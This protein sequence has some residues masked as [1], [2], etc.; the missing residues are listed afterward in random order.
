MIPSNRFRDREDA[1]RRL[2]VPLLGYTSSNPIVLGLPRGG[3]PVA[4]EVARA[5]GAPLDVWVVRKLGVPWQPE[6]AMG[7]VAEGGVVF[8]DDAL[9]AR[10]GIGP[11][12]VERERERKLL[13]VEQRVRQYR[14]DRPRPT[15]RD[16]TV[17]LVDDGIA[18]GSTARAAVRALRAE[19]PRELVLAAPVAAPDTVAELGAEFDRVVTVLTPVDLFAIGRWYD[20]F[21][22]VPDDEVR[23]LVERAAREYAAA[24]RTSSKGVQHVS[25]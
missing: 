16:R 9:I 18:T 24:Q 20:D 17:I 25:R 11:V 22:Q 1:G 14:G 3:V 10:L 23:R 7:A 4:F 15:L 21:T 6:L 8:L 12:E 5:L 19:R 2:S 13:Q